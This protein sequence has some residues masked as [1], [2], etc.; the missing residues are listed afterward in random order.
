M[1]IDHTT[2]LFYCK[3]GGSQ[4]RRVQTA[5]ACYTPTP[6][7]SVTRAI[8]LLAIYRTV[9]TTQLKMN[10]S[11]NEVKCKLCENTFFYNNR[12]IF[13]RA[14]RFL[15]LIMVSFWRPCV[16]MPQFLRGCV[17]SWKPSGD[18]LISHRNNMLHRGG[19]AICV[20]WRITERT[21]VLIIMPFKPIIKMCC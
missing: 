10:K 19:S 2:S 4:Q 15:N 18:L 9:R 14:V 17:F 6:P 3:L 12:L 20:F 13:A 5:A 11:A 8:D 1:T 21:I 7:L 16:H